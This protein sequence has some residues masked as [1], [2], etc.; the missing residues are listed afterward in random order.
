MNKTCASLTKNKQI[1]TNIV[2]KREQNKTKTRMNSVRKSCANWML[3]GNVLFHIFIFL[4]SFQMKR[5]IFG[6]LTG[7]FS[8]RG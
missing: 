4:V 7:R 2:L 6:V 1:K 3:S 8:A 5:F